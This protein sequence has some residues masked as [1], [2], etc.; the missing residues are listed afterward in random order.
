VL[1]P[2]TDDARANPGGRAL[3]GASGSDSTDQFGVAGVLV[4][5]S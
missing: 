2:R 1:F 3:P 4:G 5:H